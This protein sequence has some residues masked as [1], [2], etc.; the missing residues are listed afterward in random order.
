MSATDG[1]H[2]SGRLDGRVALVTGAARGQGRSHARRLA[3]LGADLVLVDLCAP[4]PSVPYPMATPDD[5]AETAALV[6]GAGRRALA[7]V[8]DVRD[9][10]ALA[11]AVRSATELVG[12][13]TIVIANAGIAPLSL[14]DDPAVWR[15]VVDINLTGVFHTV[16]AARPAM[17]AA[18][19]GGSVVLVSSAAGLSGA[20]N[21]TRGELAYTAAK[22]GVMGLTKAYAH[23]LAPH[24]IRV[25]A[26]LPTGVNTPMLANEA[27]GAFF[28]TFV[29]DGRNLSNAMPVGIVE[30]E[31]VTD[32]VAWL[33]SDASRFVTG[34]AVPVDAGFGINR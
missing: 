18:D 30:P 20:M 19:R 14:D 13:P 6:E 26:V 24:G 23:A 15:D 5:L 8:A 12:A 31:D 22:H 33:A 17:V 29:G 7:V 21:R 27:T 3:E 32:A 4:V 10:P 11:E 1:D 34:A 16:E 25:N 28:A 2:G 9:E